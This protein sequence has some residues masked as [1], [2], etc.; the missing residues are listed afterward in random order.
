MNE[1]LVIVYLGLLK[2]PKPERHNF[3]GRVDAPSRFRK[4]AYKQE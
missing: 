1:V 4:T 2:L 3:R